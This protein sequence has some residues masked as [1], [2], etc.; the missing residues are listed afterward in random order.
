MKR[1]GVLTGGHP[2]ILDERRVPPGSR[3]KIAKYT[4][5][6]DDTSTSSAIGSDCDE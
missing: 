3:L 1:V 4:E 5:F 2:H 6:R